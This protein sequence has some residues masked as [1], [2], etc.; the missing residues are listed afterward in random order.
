M[1][2]TL[3]DG[4][5]ETLYAGDLIGR[6]WAAA[7]RLDDP[8]VSEAH[9]MVSLRGEQLWL[10]ALRRRF[11]VAG[12]SQDAVLLTPGLI[13]RLAPAVELVVESVELPR[14]VLGLAGPGLPAR[15]IPGQ[16]SLVADPI[17]R[18]TPGFVP[19]ALAQLWSTE[20]R[21]RGRVAGRD[22]DLA[23]GTV[24]ETA[25]GRFEVVE[26][27]L[28]SAGARPTRAGDGPLR[29]VATWDTAHIHREDGEVIVLAGQLARVVSELASVRQPVA[30]EELAR[31][32][33][34]QIVERDLLRR[35]WDV[36]L[37]R[38]RERL[39]EGG[40]R[41]DLVSSTRIG[42]VEMVLREGD[43]VEDRS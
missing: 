16:S 31:Q 12:R 17:P 33:W 25:G 29:I 23:P 41:A 4:S 36:L 6:T 34:P 2:F 10:L 30:W 13:V 14:V 42:L 37:V 32:A 22:L 27:A 8:E 15:V 18:L 38:L 28:S 11:S 19:E 1:R 9:A 7:L 21:W 3:P 39:R 40:I 26:I 24:L 5:A 43:V 20:G 35:R